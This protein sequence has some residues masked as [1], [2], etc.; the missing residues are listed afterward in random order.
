MHCKTVWKAP[1]GKLVRVCLDVEGGKLHR[2]VFTGDFFWEPSDDVDALGEALEAAPAEPTEIRR[3]VAAFFSDHP[4]RLFGAT[5]EDF[6]EVVLQ[7][8]SA[9]RPPADGAQ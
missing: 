1:K 4:A 5:Q 2:V 7:A 6:A 9:S 3:R 8:L